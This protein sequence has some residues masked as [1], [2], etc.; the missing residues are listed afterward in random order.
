MLMCFQRV[1]EYSI[2]VL[3]FPYENIDFVTL[4]V[5]DVTERPVYGPS[6]HLLIE[7]FKVMKNI[8]RINLSVLI[9]INYFYE[10]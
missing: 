3:I 5:V 9:F 1:G 4:S 2:D 10:I 8:I 7:T 6:L